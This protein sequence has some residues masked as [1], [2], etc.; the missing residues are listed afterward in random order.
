MQPNRDTLRAQRLREIAATLRKAYSPEPCS[1]PEPMKD[2]LYRI[3]EAGAYKT[4]PQP[5]RPH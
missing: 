4:R 3:K 2:R 5:P 1:V